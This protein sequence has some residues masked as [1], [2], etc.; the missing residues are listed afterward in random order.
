MCGDSDSSFAEESFVKNH[1]DLFKNKSKRII[2]KGTHHCSSS[3]MGFNFL[4][5]ARPEIIFTSSAMVDTVCVPNEVSL[6]SGEGQLNHPNKSTIRRIKQTTS[7][8]YWNGING[9]ITFT[10]DG[11]N[12]MIMSGAGRHKDYYKKGTTDIAD[13]EKEKSVKFFDSEFAKYY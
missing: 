1:K 6:G 4:D 12:D 2:L 9:D 7:N 11:V 10:T 8:F 5:W 13:K 3:S